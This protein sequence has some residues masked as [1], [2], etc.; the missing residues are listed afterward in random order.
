M[1]EGGMLVHLLRMLRIRILGYLFRQY[2]HDLW[3][4]PGLILQVSFPSLGELPL[5]PSN[6]MMGSTWRVQQ[7]LNNDKQFLVHYPHL[8]QY[9]SPSIS[10]S[11]KFQISCHLA[12]SYSRI[13][14]ACSVIL[15]LGFAKSSIFSYCIL[16]KTET[17]KEVGS[18]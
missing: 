5:G 10:V 18:A 16:L 11:Q 14:G 13:A 3:S 4:Y 7:N 12:W 17:S 2:I 1:G 9:P 8:H 6:F 15:L